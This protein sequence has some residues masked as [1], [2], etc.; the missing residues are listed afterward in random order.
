MCWLME[1][2][3]AVVAL[4]VLV[5]AANRVKRRRACSTLKGVLALPAWARVRHVA[6][7]IPAVKG[8]LID[9]FP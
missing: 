8:K 3:V 1:R 6:I 5:K 7:H 9:L 4:D 2:L